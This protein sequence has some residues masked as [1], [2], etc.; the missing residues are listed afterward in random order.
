MSAR[1]AFCPHCG[2]PYQSPLTG[3]PASVPFASELLPSEGAPKQASLTAL[4]DQAWFSG[5]DW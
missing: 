1:A 2:R 5:P 4:R 3:A